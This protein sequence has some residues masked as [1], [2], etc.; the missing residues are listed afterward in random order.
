[1]AVSTVLVAVPTCWIISATMPLVAVTVSIQELSNNA[2]ILVGNSLPLLYIIT[3]FVSNCIKCLTIIGLYVAVIKTLRNSNVITKSRAISILPIIFQMVG[4]VLTNFQCWSTVC[5]IG[6]IA[7]T[8]S[9]LVS[10]LE[11]LITLVLLPLNSVINPTINTFCAP[12]FRS[13]LR[14]MFLTKKGK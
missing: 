10:S 4:I 2:C 12:Q 11:S 8:G 9:P 14:C 5:I 1:M 3:Y 7:L 13:K 6:I